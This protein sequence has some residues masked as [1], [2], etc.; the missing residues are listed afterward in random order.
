MKHVFFHC[1]ILM[2]Y[3]YT[4]FLFSILYR[5]NKI[6]ECLE[7]CLGVDHVPVGSLTKAQMELAR[8]VAQQN[9][10]DHGSS[11]STM[12]SGWTNTRG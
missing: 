2:L 12:K 3:Y 9:A 4:I 5:F 11:D 1:K 10:S 6:D 8:Q 7:V